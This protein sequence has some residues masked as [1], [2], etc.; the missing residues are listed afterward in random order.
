MKLIKTTYDTKLSQW[1][2]MKR[3]WKAFKMWLK[4]DLPRGIAML[5]GDLGYYRYKHNDET[6]EYERKDK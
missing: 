6:G 1:E 3:R 2:E 4:L 5:K